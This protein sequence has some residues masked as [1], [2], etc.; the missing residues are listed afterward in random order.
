M[1]NPTEPEG[2]GKEHR[3]RGEKGGKRH[4]GKKSAA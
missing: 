2:T 4:E 3:A 1:R